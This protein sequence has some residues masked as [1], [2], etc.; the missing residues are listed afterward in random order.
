MI[1]RIRLGAPKVGLPRFPDFFKKLR[2]SFPKLLKSK[3]IKGLIVLLVV[4]LLIFLAR[5]EHILVKGYSCKTQ[6]GPTCDK[7]DT[8]ILQRF[9]G[10]NFFTLDLKTV[11][12]DLKTNF[13]N[14]QIAVQRVLPGKINAFIVKRKPIIGAKMLDR[15][16]PG[17]FLVDKE[18]V[19]VSFVPETALGILYYKQ[20]EHNLVVGTSTD[21]KFKKAAE[22][23]YQNLRSFGAKQAELQ[24]NLLKIT[25]PEEIV[26]SYPLD[27]DTLEL[28]GALQ[29]ILTRSRIDGKLPRAVD[30]RFK[31][32]VLTY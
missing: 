13:V 8:D 11:E 19:V 5:S 22:I 12:G 27:R 1:R 14:E 3:Y 29:L 17:Y 6:Y 32:P 16:T 28:S 30:L 20:A 21:E 24:G 31:N 15:E 23:L 26:V 9:V 18:G 2:L 25:L 4:A 10:T 7:K